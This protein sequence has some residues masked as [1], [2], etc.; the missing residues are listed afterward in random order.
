MATVEPLHL[1]AHAPGS[2]QGDLAGTSQQALPRSTCCAACM[3]FMQSR[4]AFSGSAPFEWPPEE[5]AAVPPGAPCFCIPGPDVTGAMDNDRAIRIATMAR[6]G[7]RIGSFDMARRLRGASAHL[8]QDKNSRAT[9]AFGP[10]YC[11][12]AV[13]RIAWPRQGS[14][15]KR[16]APPA[17]SVMPPWAST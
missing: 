5:A 3:A 12:E 13:I 1:N 15:S 14:G 7:D 9:Q 8:G 16:A 10:L 17:C 6:T 4:I 2:A 11:G